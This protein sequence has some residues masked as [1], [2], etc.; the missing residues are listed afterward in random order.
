M[1]IFYKI[2]L[3]IRRNIIFL[4]EGKEYKRFYYAMK[5]KIDDI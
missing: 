2:F 4:L 1:R 3:W 5:E